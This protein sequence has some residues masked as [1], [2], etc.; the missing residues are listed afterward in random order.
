[1][2]DWLFPKDSVC[3][4]PEDD[5]DDLKQQKEMHLLRRVNSMD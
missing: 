4:S 1:M 2:L 5:D 3:P